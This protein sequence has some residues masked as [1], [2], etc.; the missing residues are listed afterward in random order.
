M[1]AQNTSVDNHALHAF[2]TL[3]DC[4]GHLCRF[5]LES[6][7]PFLPAF[8]SSSNELNDP[9]KA[10]E[11]SAL[12]VPNHLLSNQFLS[13][14]ALPS[15]QARAVHQALPRQLHASIPFAVSQEWQDKVWHYQVSLHTGQASQSLHEHLS[16]DCVSSI[17][18]QQ[19]ANLQHWVYFASSLDQ[20]KQQ[21]IWQPLTPEQHLRQRIDHLY[22]WLQ[23]RLQQ[24]SLIE[25][26]LILPLTDLPFGEGLNHKLS[27][28]LA[29][30][31]KLCLPN[32][33][34]L[35]ALNYALIRQGRLSEGYGLRPDKLAGLVAT[36][37]QAES[38]GTGQAED[39]ALPEDTF[40]VLDQRQ[41][42]RLLDLLQPYRS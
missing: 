38:I 34:R 37:R 26:F 19:K 7:L 21:L 30:V 42:Q 10:S 14:Q 36:L 25:H 1:F 8:T 2:F 23:L 12:V 20:L 27:D 31:G 17:P 40:L 39:E 22:D 41:C 9:L 33:E 5:P 24:A 18:E 6:L 16:R 35:P 29:R 13:N 3:G 28:S 4:F 15:H 32:R 11:S